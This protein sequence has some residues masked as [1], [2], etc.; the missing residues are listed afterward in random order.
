[1][2]TPSLSSWGGTY[3]QED[4]ALRSCSGSIRI[5]DRSIKIGI[6]HKTSRPD[7]ARQA[8][9]SKVGWS[10]RDPSPVSQRALKKTTS[11]PLC[12]E[13]NWQPIKNSWEWSGLIYSQS[14]IRFG[15]DRI[16]TVQRLKQV[17]DLGARFCF[18]TLSPKSLIVCFLTWPCLKMDTV[19]AFS[20][21]Q[22]PLTPCDMTT[23]PV[24][25]VFLISIHFTGN[26]PACFQNNLFSWK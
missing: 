7:L 3:Q 22:P 2:G 13:N 25:M 5:Y 21:L 24:Q 11:H 19:L 17:W 9:A 16:C 15:Q 12:L 8:G 1:M 23:V 20:C 10:C 18:F 26:L 14:C 4:L 6:Y